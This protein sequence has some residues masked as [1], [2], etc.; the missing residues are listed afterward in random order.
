[1]EARECLVM[2]GRPREDT[3]V[4]T[5]AVLIISRA[6]VPSHLSTRISA[7]ASSVAKSDILP[8]AVQRSGRGTGTAPTFDEKDKQDPN[9]SMAG[10]IMDGGGFETV[11]PRRPAPQGTTLG[12][13]LQ[14]A[15]EA[16]TVGL[17]KNPPEE[18]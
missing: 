10:C 7:H 18:Q 8:R 3:S 15:I 14:R 16:K 13:Y 17:V 4:S 12:E 9:F 2:L 1:M 6:T 5:V 11:Q